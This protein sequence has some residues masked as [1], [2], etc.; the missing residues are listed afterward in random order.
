VHTNR[1][2]HAVPYVQQHELVL[3]SGE[4]AVDRIDGC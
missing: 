1:H 2:T 4:E 3:I